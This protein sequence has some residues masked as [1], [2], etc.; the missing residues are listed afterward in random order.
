MFP[1]YYLLWQ[2]CFL[3]F[4]LGVENIGLLH[5]IWK[6]LCLYNWLL[7]L[8]F[9]TNCSDQF[10]ERKLQYSQRKL[11]VIVMSFFFMWLTMNPKWRLIEKKKRYKSYISNFIKVLNFFWHHSFIFKNLRPIS[12]RFTNQTHSTTYALVLM[13][14]SS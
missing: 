6:S 11:S 10:N 5:A 4:I 9:C 8:N 13:M 1:F 3:N 7:S 14:N 2:S 12:I